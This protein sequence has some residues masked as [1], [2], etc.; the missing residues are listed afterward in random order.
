MNI[1][2]YAK[3]HKH[4]LLDQIP[5][6]LD[7]IIRNN[8]FTNI[9]DVGCGG[10]LFLYSLFKREYEKGFE[11]I[12]GVDL[13][14]QRLE[15]VSRIS[16]KIK[17]VKDDA[18]ILVNIPENHFDIVVST[19]V[20][21]HVPDDQKML[22][23]LYRISKANAV[24]YIDTVFKK[25]W[26]WYFYKNGKSEPALDP[27]H[28]RE[29]THENELFDKIDRDKFKILFSKKKFVKYSM[30]NFVLRALKIRNNNIYDNPM[31]KILS[32]IQIPVP[33]YYIWKILLQKK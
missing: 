8:I 30:I 18:Q 22:E 28:V 26:A 15:S 33:G 17:T 5:D 1:E 24:I 27:T 2:E 9:I 13:S 3:K 10:G 20:I 16:D 19:Q 6:E 21:E 4:L 14:E 11:E 29:Y 23:A 25:K 31:I 7:L 12:W 32:Y